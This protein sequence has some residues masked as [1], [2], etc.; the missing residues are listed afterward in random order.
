MKKAILLFTL[1]GLAALAGCAKNPT[2]ETNAN[3]SHYEAAEPV[4]QADGSSIL[5]TTSPSGFKSEVRNFPS[6]EVVQVSRASWPEG[7]RVVTVKFR[8]GRS[9]D[10]Q[11]P[12]DYDQV[13]TASNETIAAIARKAMGTK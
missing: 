9:V 6:G 10:L 13:M 5:S 12:A 3:A 7:R 1:A 2:P 11:D 4:A 8:D